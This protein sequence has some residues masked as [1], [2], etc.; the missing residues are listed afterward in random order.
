MGF[1]RYA[2]S[3]FR[4]GRRLYRYARKNPKQTMALARSAYKGVQVLRGII[5]SEMFH[6]DSTIDLGSNQTSITPLLAI[7]SGDT[8]S[9]RTGNSLLIK[10]WSAN[11]YMYI[12]STQT[13]NTR[14]MLALVQD[15]QQVGD[16]T[17][18]INQIFSNATSPSTLLNSSNLGRFSILMRKQYS[19]SSNDAGNNVKQLKFFKRFNFHARYN[20][21]SSTDI[22]KNGLY[23]VIITSEPTKY[24]TVHFESR[25]SYHDN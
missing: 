25:I 15:K 13:T 16:T 17:P 8:D 22:Q 19:L 12:E 2:R 23:L 9:T 14:V 20:G 4:K 11:G 24:P 5:N 6:L 3:G 18:A 1:K 10:R 21:T 7:G